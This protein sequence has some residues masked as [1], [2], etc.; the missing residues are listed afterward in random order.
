MKFRKRLGALPLTV[1]VTLAPNVL[2]QSLGGIETEQNQQQRRD[3]QQREA[4]VSAPIVRSDLPKIEAY[5]ALPHESPCFRVDTFSL[6][7]LD[8]LPAA[9]QMKGASA[10]PQDPF[11]F[12]CE[13]L[14]HYSGQAMART[15]WQRTVFRRQRLRLVSAYRSTVARWRR[16]SAA[17]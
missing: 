8:S 7:V 1:L 3:A 2:A 11:A 6:K 9:T 15:R 12:A 14:D 17:T 16:A 10:L 13:W 5:P 4:A